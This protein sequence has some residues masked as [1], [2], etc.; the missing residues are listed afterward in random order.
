MRAPF[1]PTRY[2]NIFYVGRIYCR[3]PLR[4]KVLSE[5]VTVVVLVAF[6][7]ISSAPVSLAL[8]KRAFAVLR[9]GNGHKTVVVRLRP[10][11]FHPRKRVVFNFFVRPLAFSDVKAFRNI[12]LKH[13]VV[14]V[15]SCDDNRF[16]VRRIP[17]VGIKI[18]L[19]VET[20][21]KS[22]DGRYRICVCVSAYL[23]RV[24]ALFL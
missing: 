3:A 7:V 12:G 23:R 2:E 24:L 14:L 10:K 8:E 19:F 17:C 11:P 21:K 22:S 18:L 1:I 20:G 6:M 9:N 5:T 4:F 15:K 16:A 13:L